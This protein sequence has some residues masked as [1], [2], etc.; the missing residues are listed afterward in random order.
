MT[1]YAVGITELDLKRA[2]RSFHDLMRKSGSKKDP[3]KAYFVAQTSIMAMIVGPLIETHGEEEAR[4]I[5]HQAV[6]NAFILHGNPDFK[7]PWS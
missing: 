6:D 4:S 3:Q 1:E 7:S 2:A 5:L